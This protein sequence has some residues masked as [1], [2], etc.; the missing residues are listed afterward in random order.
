MDP[1]ELVYDAAVLW[2]AVD[3]LAVGCA[4]VILVKCLHLNN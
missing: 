1:E 3:E 2:E 4:R